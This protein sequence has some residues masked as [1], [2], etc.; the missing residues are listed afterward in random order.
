MLDPAFPNWRDW[1]C[2]QV[3]DRSGCMAAYAASCQFPEFS[4][5]QNEGN[6][7][8]HEVTRFEKTLAVLEHTLD[9]SVLPLLVVPVSYELLCEQV[10]YFTT[11]LKPLFEDC[12][13]SSKAFL[14]IFRQHRTVDSCYI[15]HY[16]VSR[17]SRNRWF[18]IYAVVTRTKFF[19]T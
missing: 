9:R 14:S 11:S 3:C 15:L 6:G 10:S 1:L 7:L 16:P 2:R 4:R 12:G 19:V 5:Q 18:Y 8:A 13:I 17:K